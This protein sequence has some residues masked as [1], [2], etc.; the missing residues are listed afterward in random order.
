M[1]EGVWLTYH[2]DGVEGVDD[3]KQ[4]HMVGRLILWP[5]TK[6]H[7]IR[8]FT[9]YMNM[10]LACIYLSLNSIVTFNLNNKLN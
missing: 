10:Q 9:L 7:D 3:G 8:N 6:F 4:Q 5:G 2:C 1:I